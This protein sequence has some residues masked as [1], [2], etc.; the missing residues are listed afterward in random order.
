[1]QAN[2]ELGQTSRDLCIGTWLAARDRAIEHAEAMI[3]FGLHKQIANRILEP[4][5]HINVVCTATEW[6]NWFN[7]RYH[8]DAQPEIQELARCMWQALEE[9]Q[10]QQLWYGDWHLPYLTKDDQYC[11]LET[12]KKIS[13]AR[14]ARVSYLTH[15]G[16]VPTREEDLKLFDRLM[17]NFVKHSSPT[18]H[19]ATPL[20]PN[21]PNLIKLQGN[22]QGWIQFRKTIPGEYLPEFKGPTS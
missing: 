11:D 10:P 7:L 4:W 18:E 20:T 6:G 9:S 16:K 13:A 15:E 17:A 14:C 22:L 2:E 5:M 19:Q 21:D 3:Q 1:M 8:P 12:R